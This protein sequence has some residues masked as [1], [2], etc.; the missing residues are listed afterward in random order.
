MRR[1]ILRILGFST[2]QINRLYEK[3]KEKDKH[4]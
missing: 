4:V 1:L 2:E 3:P